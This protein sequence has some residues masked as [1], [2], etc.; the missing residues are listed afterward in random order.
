MINRSIPRLIK[1]WP[2]KIND[3]WQGKKTKKNLF[4]TFLR[5]NLFYPGS[6]WQC[7]VRKW[8]DILVNIYIIALKVKN[9]NIGHKSKFCSK[10]DLFWSKIENFGQTSKYRLCIWIFVYRMKL[11]NLGFL[12]QLICL[13]YFTIFLSKNWG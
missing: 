1:Y 3:F 6:N 8:V 12:I 4:A 10:I 13:L 2:E 5:S 9:W 7:G 11:A